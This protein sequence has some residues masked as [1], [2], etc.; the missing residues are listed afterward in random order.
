MRSPIR[1]SWSPATTLLLCVAT[2][3]LPTRGE[4]AGDIYWFSLL[5]E[6]SYTASQFYS[7]LFG[8][9]M[10]DSPNGGLMAMRNGMPMAGISQIEDRLPNVSE[11]MWL[12]AITVDDL[13]KSVTTAKQLGA[14]VH[15]DITKLPGWGSFATIQDP[16]GAPVTLAVPERRL[17]GRQGYSGWRWAELWTHDTEQAA[18]FY[19]KVVGYTVEEVQTGEQHYTVFGFPGERN[20]GLV[21]LEQPEVAARWAPYVGVSDLRAILVRVWELNGKVLREPAEINF[22][23]AGNNRVALI[24]DPTGGAMFLYQLDAQATTD[25]N[26]AAQNSTS[27]SRPRSQSSES[28]PRVNVSVSV[29]YGYGYGGGWG[30]AYYP[31]G[32]GHYPY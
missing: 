10:Q 11:S 5:T 3:L 14:T 20:A 13:E 25:P 24:T 21:K 29:S 18:A 12:A 28:G 6:D 32:Y 8:W 7:Q 9:E 23:A 30:G 15:Q 17:G 31:R 2:T 19:T 4:A 1:P 27:S 16:Q 26:V 22:E